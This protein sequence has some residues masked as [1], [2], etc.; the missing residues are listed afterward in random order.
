M[1]IIMSLLYKIYIF[2]FMKLVVLLGQSLAYISFCSMPCV[3][4]FCIN[5][6]DLYRRLTQAMSILSNK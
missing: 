4:S 3:I 1:N 6:L 2:F 5:T